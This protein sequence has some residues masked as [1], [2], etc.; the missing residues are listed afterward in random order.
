MT[1]ATRAVERLKRLV[2]NHASAL[3]AAFLV[4]LAAY[5][6]W[7]VD[8]L[9]TVALLL[10][11]AAVGYLLVWLRR[12]GAKRLRQRFRRWYLLR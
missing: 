7:G 10:A 6:V 9:K 5:A 2:E 1:V 11:L 4:G 3:G 8:G 12:G